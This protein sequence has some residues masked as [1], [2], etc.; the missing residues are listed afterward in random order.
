MIPNL[1]NILIYYILPT[2]FRD[3]VMAELNGPAPQVARSNP[4]MS[5]FLQFFANVYRTRQ[6]IDVS[7]HFPRN[8]L[9]AVSTPITA[10]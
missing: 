2:K 3:G 4:A 10:L 6:P 7:A 9:L 8:G 5:V 1:I